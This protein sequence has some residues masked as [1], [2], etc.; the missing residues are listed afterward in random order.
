[1]G[2]TGLQENDKRLFSLHLFKISD[3]SPPQFRQLELVIYFFHQFFV[4]QY[5]DE[6]GLVLHLHHR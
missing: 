3:K 5:I 1:M 4:E 2:R 6:V